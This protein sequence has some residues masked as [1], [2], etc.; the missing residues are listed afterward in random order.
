[1]W[2]IALHAKWALLS[3]ASAPLSKAAPMKLTT[4]WQIGTSA[5]PALQICITNSKIR[6]VSVR[7]DTNK[8]MSATMCLDASPER[9]LPRASPATQSSNLRSWMRLASAWA[10]ISSLMEDAKRYAAMGGSLALPAMTATLWKGMVVLR[11][12][13]LRI[14]TT[15]LT[16]LPQRLRY[17]RTMENL[18][19][20]SSKVSV[21][22]TP[23][24]E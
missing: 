12:A 3:R 24:T 20:L 8:S 16:A 9:Q 4:I 11:T 15:A 22:R 19:S 14:D 17:A 10:D 5:L 7:A 23:P 6:P 13:L 21:N 1:M 2:I 18:S